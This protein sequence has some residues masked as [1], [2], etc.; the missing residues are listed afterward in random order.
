MKNNICLII[1]FYGKWPVFFPLYLK[2]CGY[3]PQIDFLFLSDLRPPKKC[4]PNVKFID[5]SLDE[6]KQRATQRLG[7]RINLMRPYKLCDLRPAFAYV[8]P[9]II[10]GYQFWGHGDID[11]IY[12]DILSF[13]TEEILNKYDVISNNKDYISGSFALFRNIPVINKLFLDSSGYKKAFTSSRN[14]GFDECNC[15]WAALGKGVDILKADSDQS[16]TYMVKKAH[17]T[18]II[19]AYFES[20]LKEIIPVGDYVKWKK[21]RI[22]Q[23]DGKEFLLYHFIWEKMRLSFSYPSWKEVPD[24]YYIDRTGFYLPEIFKTWLYYP[25]MVL[26]RLWGPLRWGRDFR[27]FVR[28]KLVFSKLWEICAPRF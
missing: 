21:G 10:H 16:M 23:K 25:L 2:S 26:K 14:M 12:G 17:F 9:E 11:V 18:G 22:F 7:F 13:L 4:P 24:K 28:K 3:N 8:F 20:N 5:M 6:I 15:L 19:N 1:P 27:E